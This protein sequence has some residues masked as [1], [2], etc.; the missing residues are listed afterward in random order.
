MIRKDDFNAQRP[1][2][3]DALHAFRAEGGVGMEDVNL[4]AEEDVAHVRE[5]G[6]EGGEGRVDVRWR[7]GVHGN[8]VDLYAVGEV[9]DPTPWGVGVRYD[10]DLG[11]KGWVSSTAGWV[12]GVGECYFVV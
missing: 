3:K 7:E 10:Y 11:E 9:A 8:V 6:E 5:R 12:R 4:L 1:R 2:M